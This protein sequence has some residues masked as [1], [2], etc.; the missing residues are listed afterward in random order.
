MNEDVNMFDYGVYLGI[1]SIVYSIICITDWQYVTQL[2]ALCSWKIEDAYEV[3][4][5]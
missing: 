4:V 1:D 3:K 2:Y 5:G